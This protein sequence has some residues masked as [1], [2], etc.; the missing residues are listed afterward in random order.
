MGLE[1]MSNW[2]TLAAGVDISDMIVNSFPFDPS[3]SVQGLGLT[4][5]KHDRFGIVPQ[6][7]LC[8]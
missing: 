1:L 6:L 3:M 7:I 2:S 8:Y 4:T 5:G